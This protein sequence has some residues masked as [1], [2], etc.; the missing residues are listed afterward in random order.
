MISYFVIYELFHN[1]L[2][3]LLCNAKET[4]VKQIT[5]NN[6]IMHRGTFLTVS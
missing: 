6:I 5:L 1:S 2:N 4:L 3:T